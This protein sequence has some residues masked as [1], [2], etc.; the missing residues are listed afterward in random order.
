MRWY[1]CADENSHDQSQTI[2]IDSSTGSSV[3]ELNVFQHTLHI[4]A[5]SGFDETEASIDA[6]SNSDLV[7]GPGQVSLSNQFA[8]L[9]GPFVKNLVV[10]DFGNVF[11]FGSAV[12]VEVGCVAVEVVV[13]LYV[14][15]NVEKFFVVVLCEFDLLG[16]VI[17]SVLIGA[18]LA[19]L[20]GLILLRPHGHDLLNP[21]LNNSTF[22]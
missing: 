17:G 6:S 15:K 12:E 19:W 5:V 2:Q 4:H 7:L 11:R 14:A 20:V 1:I 3:L 10:I 13:I 18:S 21:P 8:F 16:Q 9:N 22:Q